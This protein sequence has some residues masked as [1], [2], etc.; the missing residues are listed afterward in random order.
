MRPIGANSIRTRGIDHLIK[1]PDIWQQPFSVTN[2]FILQYEA[3]HIC[4]RLFD[5]PDNAGAIAYMPLAEVTEEVKVIYL[6]A[7]E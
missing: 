5:M 7:D 3:D 1:R 4:P 2:S 6:V